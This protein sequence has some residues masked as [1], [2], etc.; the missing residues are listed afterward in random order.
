MAVHCQCVN[1]S[2]VLLVEI[3]WACFYWCLAYVM[4]VK[5]V[6]VPVG[7]RQSLRRGLT[8]VGNLSRFGSSF[9]LCATYSSSTV[10]LLIPVPTWSKQRIETV[11]IIAH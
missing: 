5:V 8:C 2:A 6:P 3:N 7:S 9:Y 1:L 10:S 11:V 4:S